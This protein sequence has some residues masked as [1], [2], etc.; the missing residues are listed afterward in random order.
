[1]VLPFVM[2]LPADVLASGHTH[3]G[4]VVASPMTPLYGAIAL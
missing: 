1:M 3:A 2:A 4:H